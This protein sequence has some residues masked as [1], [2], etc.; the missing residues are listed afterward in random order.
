MRVK[1]RTYSLKKKTH[2]NCEQL[3][4]HYYLHKIY[5]EKQNKTKKPKQNVYVEN[6]GLRITNCVHIT[7][8][9]FMRNVD[10]KLNILTYN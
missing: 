2:D 9:N 3:I 4:M 5:I 6:K 7:Q 8:S 1:I 10:Y